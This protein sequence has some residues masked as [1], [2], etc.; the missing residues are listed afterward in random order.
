MKMTIK[1]NMDYSI[2][3][4]KYYNSNIPIQILYNN[5]NIP[6]DNINDYSIYIKYF[7]KGKLIEKEIKIDNDNITKPLY[8]LFE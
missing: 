8:T 3:N 5:M 7:I 2:D 4:I 1:T 6:T